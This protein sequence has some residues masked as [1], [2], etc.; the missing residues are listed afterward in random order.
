MSEEKKVLE[1]AGS[2]RRFRDRKPRRGR[3]LIA[4]AAAIAL[5]LTLFFVIRPASTPEDSQPATSKVTLIARDKTSLRSITVRLHDHA[6]YTLVN[7]NEYD[8]ADENEDLGREYALEGD[9]SFA[10]STTQ[11]L[12]MERYA[13]DL[14]AEDVAAETP[15]NLAEYGLTSPTMTVS[16]A[17]RDG[18]TE[19][20]DFGIEVPTGGGVYMKR[21]GDDA[22]YIAS[23]SVYDAFGRELE[24]LRQTEEER[25]S[26]E[27]AKA[28]E[29]AAAAPD[30][31]IEPSDTVNPAKDAAN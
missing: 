14:V 31:A 3:V 26:I 11:V 24:S 27:N 12:S 28:A 5:S 23:Y 19:T 20:F 17:F 30:E 29:K 13:T 2:L 18:K 22:V 10:V 6:P 9:D 8:L 15:E 25:Q 16:I 4:L 21:A 1:S 7:L